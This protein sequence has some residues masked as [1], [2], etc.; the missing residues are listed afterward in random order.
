[1]Q[2]KTIWDKI[3]GHMSIQSNFQLSRLSESKT[4]T[5]KPF[6]I[7]SAPQFTKQ[8]KQLCVRISPKFINKKQNKHVEVVQYMCKTGN[9][10]FEGENNTYIILKKKNNKE[11]RAGKMSHTPWQSLVVLRIL[12]TGKSLS[13]SRLVIFREPYWWTEKMRW[14][15]HYWKEK[16]SSIEGGG[17]RLIEDRGAVGTSWTHQ[18]SSGDSGL[19]LTRIL[20]RSKALYGKK[21]K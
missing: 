17:R 10:G 8:L 14:E 11:S 3:L 18:D 16:R 21:W 20:M 4:M 2:P 5:W 19:V 6:S 1:M 13:K 9:S 7:V 15:E 12:W